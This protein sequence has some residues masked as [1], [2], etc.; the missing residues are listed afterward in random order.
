MKIN[1]RTST[2]PA[3]TADKKI[4]ATCEALPDGDVVD[5]YE[6]SS[7]T[8]YAH[9]TLKGIASSPVLSKYRHKR[10]CSSTVWFGN[11]NTIAAFKKLS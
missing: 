9:Q 3:S 11:A 6:L 4:I 8:G 10:N 2:A 7:L 5:M 1:F